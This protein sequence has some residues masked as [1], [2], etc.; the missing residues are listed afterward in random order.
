MHQWSNRAETWAPA[1]EV[2]GHA[3]NKVI[4]LA[5]A[6]NGFCRNGVG[7]RAF[8]PVPFSLGCTERSRILASALVRGL[9]RT[10]VAGCRM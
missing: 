2:R 5:M 9:A 10:K 6:T 7:Y 3:D 8:M 1:G 4:F